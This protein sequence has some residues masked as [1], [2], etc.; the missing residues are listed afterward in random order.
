[1]LSLSVPLE[2]ESPSPSFQSQVRAHSQQGLHKE[3]GFEVLG[4]L[5][6]VG[7]KSQRMDSKDTALILL[8]CC[9]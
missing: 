6:S 5:R 7:T 9:R 8:R 3:E 2:I 4:Q 1:M